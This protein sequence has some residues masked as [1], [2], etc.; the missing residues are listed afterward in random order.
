VARARALVYDPYLATLGGGERYMFAVAET[1]RG[2]FDVVVGGRDVP[3][4]STLSARG[5]PDDFVM[6]AMSDREFTRQ[7]ASFDLAVVVTIDIPPRS[8]AH[9]SLLIVQFPFA[10]FRPWRPIRALERA[11]ILRGYQAVVYSDFVREWATRRWHINARVISPTIDRGLPDAAAK[12]QTILSIGR[13]NTSGNR[14]RQDVLIDAF[15]SLPESVRSGWR[16]VLAGAAP[17]DHQTDKYLAT[18]RQQAAGHRIE[19]ALNVPQVELVDLL[20]EA[21][22]YWHAAGYG[23]KPTQPQAAEH[24]GISTVEAMSWGAVPLVYDDGGQHEIVTPDVGVRWQTVEEL[25]RETVML[26]TDGARRAELSRS[27]VEASKSY[28]RERFEDLVLSSVEDL[29]TRDPSSRR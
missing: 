4:P 18:L 20:G 29:M 16:L 7:S 19:F 13:F 26:M 8:R 15:V 27:A 11:R 10:R 12:G 25:V 1:I 5:L 21:S 3:L 24:F 17:V 9:S 28:S 14:K 6:S 22:L 23:R 2:S